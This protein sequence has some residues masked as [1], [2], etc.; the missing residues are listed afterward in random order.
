MWPFWSL[1]AGRVC[2][3]VHREVCHKNLEL[4]N[5]LSSLLDKE[6]M[7]QER[8]T[9]GRFGKFFLPRRN[10]PD[11]P[12]FEIVDWLDFWKGKNED[13][14]CTVLGARTIQSNRWIYTGRDTA[15]QIECD[16]IDYSIGKTVR[17]LLNDVIAA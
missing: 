5:S 4:N 3:E 12:K 11:V 9:H 6:A 14:V 10:E 7:K 8:G 1:E 16:F 15:V 2:V 17:R 13:F